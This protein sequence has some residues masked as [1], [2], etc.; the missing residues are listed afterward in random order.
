MNL[1]TNA[2]LGIL[3]KKGQP[4]ALTA[5]EPKGK[6][7]PLKPTSANLPENPFQHDLHSKPPQPS[8]AHDSGP[9]R[10]LGSWLCSW[11]LGPE[12]P[13]VRLE[14]SEMGSLAAAK[15]KT[16]RI[17]RT[18]GRLAGEEPEKR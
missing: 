3:E 6:T 7:F 12:R 4:S 10:S 17:C 13:G 18:P 1:E 15:D 11:T 8:L 5:H 14:G 16:L 2:G 9:A